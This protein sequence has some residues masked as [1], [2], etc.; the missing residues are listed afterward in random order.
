MLW[1]STRLNEEVLQSVH[2]GE[3]A[4]PPMTAPPR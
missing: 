1:S 3:A 2:R 4:Q